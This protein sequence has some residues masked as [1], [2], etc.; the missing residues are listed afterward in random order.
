MTAAIVA[1]QTTPLSVAMTPKTGV[2]YIIER[3]VTA[4]SVGAGIIPTI[5]MGEITHLTY[6]FIALNGNGTNVAPYYDEPDSY[7][8][9]CA[10]AAHAAGKKFG[11]SFEDDQ[12][13]NDNLFTIL[14]N[15]TQR[16]QLAS[17]IR[18]WLVAHNA[19]YL[20]VD[21][22][23][24]PRDSTMGP[25]ESAFVEDVH[26]VLSAVGKTLKLYGYQDLN[27]YANNK[28]FDVDMTA[29]ALLDFVTLSRYGQVPGS[30]E[31]VELT[32]Q[33][34]ANAGYLPKT[35]LVLVEKLGTA[36][37]TLAYTQSRA[38]W[39]INNGFGGMSLF[40][41]D[42]SSDYS[43]ILSAVYAALG[44]ATPPPGTY[45]ITATAGAN[46]AISPAGAVGI[47]SGASQT[48]IITPNSG[49]QV[50]SV[51][52]D[53]VSQ[54]A[55][56]SYTFTNIIANH[57]FSAS[58]VSSGG[59]VVVFEEYLN[60]PD[61]DNL[62]GATWKAYTFTPTVSHSATKIS[63]ELER[64]GTAAGNVVVSIRATDASG[65]PTGPDLASASVPCSSIAT[66]FAWYDFALSTAVQ[67]AA[68]VKYAIVMRAPSMTGSNYIWYAMDRAG[69]Y[70]GGSGFQSSNSGSSWSAL[71]T[72]DCVFE[73]WGSN[74]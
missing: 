61:I 18:D 72:F 10:N 70:S 34:W 33:A 59:T 28:L 42:D 43:N 66:S 37:A 30:G 68:G 6:N 60:G 41:A 31:E 63:L 22:E 47:N 71:A 29:F 9:E 48:F 74:T 57:T 35:K 73:V 13:W 26:T 49:Y 3:Y 51:L 69:S 36:D 1:G 12:D 8:S 24:Y 25:L 62:V 58:F 64:A 2:S 5:N 46:G 27:T 32:L 23:R 50:S 40:D 14:A 21:I 11:V 16:M 17:N 55:I 44:G 52:V 45:T 65:N 7:F 19:D 4:H 54:G 15:P 38:Q 39:V 56:T 53:G 20:D 67:L